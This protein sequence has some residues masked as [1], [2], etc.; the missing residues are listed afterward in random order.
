MMKATP[1]LLKNAS[2]ILSPQY[3]LTPHP[4]LRSSVQPL[5]PL[6]V[7]FKASKSSNESRSLQCAL[8][9]DFSMFTPVIARYATDLDFGFYLRELCI[10][11]QPS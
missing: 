6:L 2:V 7:P 4:G 9:S 8:Q 11:V 1:T 3:N 5:S 10:F